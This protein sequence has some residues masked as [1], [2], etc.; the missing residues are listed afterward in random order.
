[1]EV[2]TSYLFKSAVWLTGF[3]IVYILFLRNERYFF[4]KRIYLISGIIVSLLFPFITIHYSVELPA[5]VAHTAEPVLSVPQAGFPV[6][7]VQEEK[8]F[9]FTYIITGLYLAGI[10]FLVF[11]TGLHF[12]SLFKSIRKSKI[13]HI[14]PAKLVRVSE[15]PSSFSFFNYIFVNPSVSENEVEQIMHHELV[16][17][18]Q[19]HWFDLMLGELLRMIQWA[20]PFAWVYTG[21]IRLNHEYLADAVALQH[22]ADPA[23]YKAALLNQM[24]RTPVISLSNSFNYS[25][26]KT[27]FDMMKKIIFSPYRKLKVLFVL[28]VFALVFYA[29]ATP[30]YHY[31]ASAINT[32]IAEMTIYS[33]PAIQQKEVRGIVL[34]EDGKPLQ[35]VNITSTGTAG[36]AFGATT[37]PDGRFS[38]TGLPQ[39]ASL[40]FFCRGYKRITLKPDFSKEMTVKMEKDPEYKEPAAQPPQ[41]QFQMPPRVVTIDGVLTDKTAEEVRKELGYNYGIMNI[42]RGIPSADKPAVDTVKIVTRKKALAMGLK[43]PFPRLAPEDFPTFQG[44]RFSYFQDWFKGQ[45][46]YPAEAQAQKIEGWVSVNFRVQLDGTLSDIQSTIPANPLLSNEALRVINS[47][48]KWD[49][50]KNPDVDEPLTQSITMKFKLPDQ[51]LMEAPFVVVEEMPRYPGGDAELL[52]YIGDNTIYPETARLEK[53]EGRVI[54]RFVVSSEGKTEAISV[55]KGVHPLLDAEAIRVVSTISGWTPGMQGGKPVNVWY[56]V[57]ITFKLGTAGTPGPPK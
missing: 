37:G 12:F 2:F 56:M 14:G 36:N 27:R 35:G 19:K 25:L 53:I 48:P 41:A 1:M 7:Q 8:G 33:A 11:R 23:V 45:V 57:P 46:R 49:P 3:T 21:F 9:N 30:E 20:N 54:V 15:F 52:K 17:V 32:S 13:N 5:P 50:P 24:F 26:N 51:I 43:P 34:K 44:Q 31:A 47:S 42:G 28:P 4:L 40:L 22:S 10:V 55:L 6:Q 16:H 18:K 38:F 39:D 29:F